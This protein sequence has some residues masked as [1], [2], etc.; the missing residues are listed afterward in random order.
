MF[1]RSSGILLHPTS[2]PG[3]HGIGELGPDAYAF[4]D[5][6]ERAGQHVWQVLPLAPT[7]F[8]DSPYQSFS[9]FAGNAL[10]ISLDSLEKEGLLEALRPPH[11]PEERV[12][13]GA[14][15]EWKTAVLGSVWRR[16]QARGGASGKA[17]LEKF[18][19]REAW[20]LEDFT[21]F[22]EHKQSRD[23]GETAFL[24]W[25]FYRQ[26]CELKE[27]ANGKDIRIMGDLPIYV[28]GDSA[29]VWAHPELFQMDKLS[30]V[31]PDYFSETGQLWGNPIY[32]WEAL[33]AGGY[34]WWIER[35]RAT[36]RQFDYI[37]LDHFRGFEAYWEVRA[38]AQNAI[39]GRW[40]KGPGA[41]LFRILQKALGPLPVVAE[42]LGVITPEVEAIRDEFGFPGMAVLQFAFGADPQ[43]P[44]FRPHNF[45]RN[46]VA[47]TGTH[48]NDT[49]RGWW[50]GSST[51]GERSFGA[52]YLAIDGREP[53][54]AF[55]RALMASVADLVLFPLQDVLGL[56]AEARMNVP[57]T[58]EGN[59]V[60]RFR[61]GA[62]TEESA[63][64][65]RELGELYE[66]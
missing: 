64:R 22:M 47:Y 26:W 63:A 54:W 31:P 36:L 34:R 53:N 25:I 13:Y 66:R 57:A 24:Q 17:E 6:L 33:K 32:N 27:Y 16:F 41:E 48:D 21:R 14:V 4:V 45:P 55:I 12:D 56:G 19:A 51:P 62:L 65:L 2:L 9:A 11:F 10:L 40:V 49:T 15:I 35:F 39:Q 7:G 52:R 59:W 28:A 29:D 60:W 46:L 23:P 61:R 37:R 3:P 8:G 43:A 44:S 42:N 1:Q 30:G 50:E 5:Y 58:T 20:W 18:R 38:P